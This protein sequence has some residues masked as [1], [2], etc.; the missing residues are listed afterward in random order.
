MHK[1]KKNE[2]F[3]EIYN[4]GNKFFGYYSLVYIRKNNL[5]YNRLGVVAS[6]K[7]GNAIC[8]TRLKRLLREFFRLN[9]NELKNG[10]DYIFI[11]KRTAGQKF[12]TLK[13]V[14]IE[15]DCRK[16]LK[17]AGGIMKNI[18]I[19]FIKI[20]QKVISPILG[21]RC[22]FYPTCSNYAISAL[23]KHGIVK[24]GILTIKRL[25]KCHPFNEGGYDPVP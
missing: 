7:T 6:K 9:E 14:D 5:K 18:L 19:F 4:K 25:L 22:R 12:K 13:Y 1:L 8:R 11:A 21:P 20:Y 17:K 24:G 10:Y 23:K 2:Q 3:Q 16:I 15:K